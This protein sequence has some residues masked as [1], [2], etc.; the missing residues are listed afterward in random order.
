MAGDIEQALLRVAARSAGVCTRGELIEAGVSPRTITARAAAG[1]LVRVGAGVF[2]IPALVGEKTP[3][4]RAVRAHRPGALSHL[5]AARLWALPV[6]PARPEDPVELTVPRPA[7]T[8]AS[9]AGVVIHRVRNWSDVDVTEPIPGS[10]TTS[11]ARTIVD[12]SGT[13]VGDRRL[14]HVVQVSLTSKLVSLEEVTRCLDRLG[15]RGVT[16]SGRLRRLLSGFDDG[17]GVPQSELEW[18][19]AELVDDRFQRQFRPPWYDGVRG[20]VDLADPRSHTIVEADGRRWHAIE[21]AMVEDRRRD[22]LAAAN[23]WLVLRVTGHDVVHRP[24]ATAA[25]IDA[26]VAARSGK[27][28]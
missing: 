24:E 8:R 12:L 5:T 22:R 11:P 17:G 27:A 14:R 4:F 26:A 7:S 10:P 2:E 18:R 9:V 25:D 6:A 19:L 21:Q 20:V 1:S 23:G 16:G 15:G 3:L 13:T 28:A